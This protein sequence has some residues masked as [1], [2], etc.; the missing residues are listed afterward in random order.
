MGK[1]STARD[2]SNIVGPPRSTTY[3]VKPTLL[4]R[5]IASDATRVTWSPFETL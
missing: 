5:F 3:P 4:P 1:W 2:L